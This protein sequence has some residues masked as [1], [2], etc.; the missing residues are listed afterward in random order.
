MKVLW[1]PELFLGI[2]LSECRFTVFL[3]L[4]CGVDSWRVSWRATRDSLLSWRAKR[5]AVKCWEYGGKFRWKE[6][7]PF[8]EN[9]RFTLTFFE[10]DPQNS[11]SEKSSENR[12]TFSVSK[13]DPATGV[14]TQCT[15]KFS[16]FLD[17]RNASDRF[18][19]FSRDFG[20]F[21]FFFGDLHA[22]RHWPPPEIC[23]VE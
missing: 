10:K 2:L 5:G 7:C 23:Q 8:H 12:E 1:F 14:I 19:L 22:F 18:Q 15:Y 21:G 16:S 6:F 9:T 13:F 3:P 11:N 4:D 20:L 17:L